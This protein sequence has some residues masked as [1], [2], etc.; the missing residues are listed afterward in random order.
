[1]VAKKYRTKKYYQKQ[2]TDIEN[3]IDDEI[4]KPILSS[5]HAFICFDTIESANH[6]LRKFKLGVCDGASLWIRNLK[7]TLVACC[8]REHVQ[9]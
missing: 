3:E 2:I 4:C 5:G 7:D 9:K 6:C 8:K 1:M